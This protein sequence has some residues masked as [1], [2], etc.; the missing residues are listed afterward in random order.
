MQVLDWNMMGLVPGV[1]GRC[2]AGSRWLHG[3]RGRANRRLR[4]EETPPQQWLF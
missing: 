2:P 3:L 1:L 4:M